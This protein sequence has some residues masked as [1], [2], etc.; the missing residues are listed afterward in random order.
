[1][2][3]TDVACA[4]RAS[5]ASQGAMLALGAAITSLDDGFC[6]L[7]M[8]F[9]PA[10]AQQHGYFHGGVLAA[11]GDSAGGYAANTKLMPLRECLTAEYKINM[12]SPATGEALLARGR[13]IRPG[14]S[15]V[16]ATV[17]LFARKGGLERHCALMQMTLFAIDS[18]PTHTDPK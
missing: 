15:L 5:F 16:I 17:D 11:L 10:V 14:R 8:P 6:E 9:S 12:L 2:I 3:G 18:R 13:V 4:V 7:E 1:M